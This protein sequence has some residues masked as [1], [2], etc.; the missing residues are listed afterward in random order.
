MYNISTEVVTSPYSAPAGIPPGP[1]AFP[2]LICPIVRLTSS[3]C[4]NL[5]RDLPQL[6]VHLADCV[7]LVC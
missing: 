1:A 3:H 6:A 4:Y 7:V 5:L 2:F